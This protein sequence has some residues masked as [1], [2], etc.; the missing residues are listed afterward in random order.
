[1]PRALIAGIGNIFLRDDGFG[2]AVLQRLQRESLPPWVTAIDFGIRSVHLVYELLNDY[3]AILLVDATSR[4]GPPGTLYVLDLEP[5]S[6][7]LVGEA[8]LLDPHALTPDRALLALSALR[9]RTV[10]VRLIGCEPG[11][12]EEGMELTPPVAAAVDQAV[13]LVLEQL[14][15]LVGTS[16]EEKGGSSCWDDW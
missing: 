5:Q 12:V 10:R 1:M 2:S 9:G 14:A 6:P 16:V 15:E 7:D 3:D 8:M 13:Q 4:G 11:S